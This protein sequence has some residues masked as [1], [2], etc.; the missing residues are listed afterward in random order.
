MCARKLLHF[1]IHAKIE[2][3]R[4]NRW[5]KI[6]ACFRPHSLSKASTFA[7]SDLSAMRFACS[8][9]LSMCIHVPLVWIASLYRQ[10]GRWQCIPRSVHKIDS[11]NEDCAVSDTCPDIDKIESKMHMKASGTFPGQ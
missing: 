2:E 9:L 1:P 5:Q 6:I 8:I 7:L 10:I 4:M 3:T 11:L